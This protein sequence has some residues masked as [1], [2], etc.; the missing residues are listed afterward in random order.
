MLSKQFSVYPAHRPVLSSSELDAEE[1]GSLSCRL[2]SRTHGAV[3]RTRW[4]NTNTGCIVDWIF[5][6]LGLELCLNISLPGYSVLANADPRHYPSIL[7]GSGAATSPQFASDS[8]RTVS[9]A[10]KNFNRESNRGWRLQLVLCLC[11]CG[12]AGRAAHKLACMFV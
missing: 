8:P 11:L 5:R 4:S 7:P 1:A 2:G 6:S 9:L 12:A 10:N 3:I